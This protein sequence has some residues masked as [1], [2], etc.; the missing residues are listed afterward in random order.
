[1]GHFGSLFYSPLGEANIDLIDLGPGLLVDT[2]AHPVALLDPVLELLIRVAHGA[3]VSVVQD[4]D[5]AQLHNRVEDQDVTEGVANVTAGIA[6]DDALCSRHYNQSQHGQL[7][8]NYFIG[9]SVIGISHTARLEVEDLLGRAARVAAGD[10]WQSRLVIS[11]KDTEVVE[12]ATRLTNEG[13]REVDFL[14]M[15]TL[16]NIEERRVLHVPRMQQTSV[17][18]YQR[19]RKKAMH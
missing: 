2:L 3:A 8:A 18:K 9:Q 15:L 10:W 13:T 12:P 4:Q 17:F 19:G 1:M 16:I 7:L 14:V 6:V 11:G 5:L